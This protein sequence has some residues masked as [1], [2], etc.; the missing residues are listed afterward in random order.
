MS[1]GILH[2][3]VAEQT[4]GLLGSTPVG[5]TGLTPGVFVVC[6]ML[7]I[8]PAATAAFR[9][10]THAAGR[11]V[12]SGAPVGYPADHATVVDF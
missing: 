10:A 2:L 6:G 5:Y 8:F 7:G 9:A 12:V 11:L 1:P 4:D 3:Y